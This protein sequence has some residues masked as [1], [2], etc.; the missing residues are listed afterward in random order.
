MKGK[1]INRWGDYR[2]YVNETPYATTGDSPYKKLSKQNCDEIF[3]VVDIEPFII[4][5]SKGRT[6]DNES[7]ELGFKRAVK[8]M[9]DK[10]FSENDMYKMFIYGRSI[11]TAKKHVKE[12]EDKP[13]DEFFNDFIQSLQQ[14][15]W[16][17]IM[18]MEYDESCCKDKCQDPE[19]DICD[20]GCAMA[21]LVPKLD[22]D[23]CLIL[24]R[25]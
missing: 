21:T 16:D 12:L 20:D 25:I 10:K 3:G 8:L 5:D 6:I 18:E 23:G 4:E 19:L 24:K 15:E 11:D 22:A 7:Y 13:I 9:G 14:T 2:L 17:V 1:L